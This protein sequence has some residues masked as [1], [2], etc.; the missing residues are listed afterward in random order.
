MTHS[1]IRRVSVRGMTTITC[2]YCGNV[3]RLQ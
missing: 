1:I 3:I 2:E